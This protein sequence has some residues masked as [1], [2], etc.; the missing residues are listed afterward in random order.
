MKEVRHEDTVPPCAPL[1]PEFLGPGMVPDILH[2]GGLAGTWLSADPEKT[3]TIT[4]PVLEADRGVLKDPF[5]RGANLVLNLFASKIKLLG[6]N[7]LD[8]C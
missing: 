3:L 8:Y 6:M 5:E 7:R 1:L 4:K 2:H